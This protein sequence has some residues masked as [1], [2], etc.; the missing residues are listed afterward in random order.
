MTGYRIR[1]QVGALGA[2]QKIDGTSA[3]AQTTEFTSE[4]IVLIVPEDTVR[5]AVGEDPT[6]DT[7]SPLLPEGVPFYFRVPTGHKIAI[8]GG[9]ANITTME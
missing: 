9:V 1:P 8:Q 2:N 6:A 3:S 4:T 7:N 5:V